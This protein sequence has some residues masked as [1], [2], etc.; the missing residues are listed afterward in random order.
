MTTA[1][2]LHRLVR[3]LRQ[4]VELHALDRLSDTELLQEFRTR[5][6][7][8]AF[9][10]IVQRHGLCVLAACRG[11]LSSEAD[12]E[13]VFQ[14]TFIVLLRSAGTVRQSPSLRSWLYS[15]AH[16]LALK[17][18]GAAARRQQVEQQKP[19]TAVQPPDLSWP[20]ACAILHEELDR[21][22]D[23][24][25]LPLLLC[26][27]EGKSRDEAAQQL[28][29]KLDV[30]RGRLERG[31][32][33][34]RTRLTKRG[35]TLSTG[36]LAAVANSVTAG[37]PPES[38]LRATLT[39]ATTG[40]IPA[41]VAAL[42]HGATPSMTL[43]K[44]KL[45]AVALLMLGLITGGVGLSMSDAPAPAARPHDKKPAEAPKDS[46][47]RAIEVRGQVLGPDGKPAAGAKVYLL[48]SKRTKGEA[49]ATADAE[50]KFHFSAKPEDVGLDGRVLA[51][52]EGRAPD[53]IELDR[54]DKGAITLR[55][56]ADDVPFTGRVLTLEG[57]PV[58]GATVEAERIGKQAD[59]DLR[60]WL[61]NN[62]KLR[63]DSF[64]VNERG[65]VTVTPSAFGTRLTATTDRDGKFRLVG[66]G[67]DRVLSVRVRGDGI[68]HKFFW[69]VTRLDAPKDGY[70]KTGETNYGLY[71]PEMTVL[72]GPS[73]PFVGT[74]R[75]RATGEPIAG[76]VVEEVERG[77]TQTFT[78]A[79]GQYR[80]EGVPK[81]KHYTLAAAGKEGVPYFDTNSDRVEDTAGF[82][83]I[84]VDFMLHRGVEIT[85][86]ILDKD[87]GTPVA[88]QVHYDAATDNPNRKDYPPLDEARVI[89]SRW[90]RTCPDGTFTMLAIPGPGAVSVCGKDRER[91]PIVNARGELMKLSIRSFPSEP[92]HAVLAVNPD[93]KKP[94]SLVYNFELQ[95]GKSRKG[96]VVGPDGKPLEGV[97][98]AGLV[99]GG[100]P[101]LMKSP[102]F[103]TAGL[104]D[105]DRILIFIHK[106]K[107]LGSVVI[108]RDD[109]E[110]AITVRMKP[111][112][113]IEGRIL[114][115]D[116]KPWT[117]LK[118]TLHPERVRG[119]YDNVPDET[120]AFQGMLGIWRALWSKFLK[121][122]VVTD[123][124][125]RFRLEGVLPG[126]AFGLF[127]SDGPLEKAGTLVGEKRRVR[128][129][130]GQVLDLGDWKP[131]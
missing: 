130:A 59:G 119:E 44:W 52:G 6:N 5:G 19:L 43:G 50:G 67:S 69:G 72:V 46:P 126:V 27:L 15:V 35:V 82:G 81:K 121:R 63:K 102:V 42:L 114:D 131:K 17:A 70:I 117:G 77:V 110:E 41:S 55:L 66:A 34:L 57:Q 85:G 97:T 104:S 125:G 25:R 78:D 68:E 87:T 2:P 26:Y 49:I 93:P 76:I 112:G 38:L 47:P 107:N 58:A 98:A 62:V 90:G 14:A 79:R 106:E 128:L 103:T 23:T 8:E 4:A 116:G 1:A 28:S 21:L 54:C 24:Y 83:P 45:L 94:E 113:A 108:V 16:R 9:T 91:Y 100:R 123:K 88:A 75:D 11:V 32:D 37:G 22:P 101:E 56:G 74:V 111:L 89:I 124:E 60:Q 109:S 80:L 118:L 29:C 127:V 95:P 30:L 73:K 84:T 92:V 12:V 36:L 3:Q 20:E 99:P 18:L 64:W 96:T 86:R 120:I 48:G 105:R 53:W 10:A 71:G 129:E 115:A 39:A 65:L 31:R 13:D 122:E 40:R 33:R 61:D 7:Q 51:I